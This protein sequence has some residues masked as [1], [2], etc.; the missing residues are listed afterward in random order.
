MSSE[1]EVSVAG[2]GVKFK[3]CGFRYTKAK[4]CEYTNIIT[5]RIWGKKTV[6][7]I[8]GDARGKITSRVTSLDEVEK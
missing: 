6:I 2:H 3:R 8:H 5:D 4:P 1:I 7:T